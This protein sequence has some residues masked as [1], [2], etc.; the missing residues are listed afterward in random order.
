MG[1]EDKIDD[2]SDIYQ[3]DNTPDEVLYSW[4]MQATTHISFIEGYLDVVQ[5][6]GDTIDSAQKER[7]FIS[8][9][10]HVQQLKGEVSAAQRRGAELSRMSR[11][12]GGEH[13]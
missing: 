4:G 2:P 11:M 8:I 13:D 12:P 7:F 5:N 6:H 3:Y 9:N 1:S 10:H